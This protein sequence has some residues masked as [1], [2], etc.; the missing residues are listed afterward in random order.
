MRFR[1][2]N[3]LRGT[4]E[5]DFNTIEQ[6]WYW[7][8]HRFYLSYPSEMGRYVYMEVQEVNKYGFTE[9]ITC[10][11][12]IHSMNFGKSESAKYRTLKKCKRE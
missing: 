2:G 5:G 1:M 4:F 8:S 9:F 7:L 10:K 12:G 11:Q 3:I 6:A